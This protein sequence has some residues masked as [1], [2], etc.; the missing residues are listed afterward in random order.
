MTLGKNWQSYSERG[1]RFSLWLIRAIASRFGRR[2][3]RALM[4]FI[5][6]YYLLTA[7]QHCRASKNYLRRVLHREPGWLDVA[8][9]IHC[10]ASTILD[11][12]YFV[13]DRIDMVSRRKTREKF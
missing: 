3:A 10:F 8:R 11:R 4:L 12:I 6:V 13:T 7:K 1:N 5:T 9:H 2:F